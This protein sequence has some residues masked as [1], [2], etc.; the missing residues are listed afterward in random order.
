M[1]NVVKAVSLVL[2][3]CG[4]LISSGCG[5]KPNNAFQ[6]DKVLAMESPAA[7]KYLEGDGFKYDTNELG[8]SG[9]ASKVVEGANSLLVVFGDQPGW[10]DASGRIGRIELQKGQPLKAVTV[11]YNTRSTGSAKETNDAV[12]AA[13]GFKDSLGTSGQ[14]GS[15]SGVDLDRST[16][17][18]KSDI[19]GKP[20]VVQVS[21][22]NTGG[23]SLVIVS[24][25]YLSDITKD[26]EVENTYEAY[27]AHIKD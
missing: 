4:V 5:S 18:F 6:V 27:S 13:A 26:S 8:W 1:R 12:V 23:N 21:V 24:A 7:V 3:L 22:S 10:G 11:A 14:D 25:G 16:A 20:G 19:N 15:S 9:D 17:W 2:V